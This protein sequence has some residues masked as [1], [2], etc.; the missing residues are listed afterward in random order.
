[1]SLEPLQPN[2]LLSTVRA[3]RAMIPQFVLDSARNTE[4][5]CVSALGLIRLDDSA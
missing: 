4:M 5:S 2:I 1:M 3:R